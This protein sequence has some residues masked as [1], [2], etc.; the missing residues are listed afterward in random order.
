MSD[1]YAKADTS[2]YDQIGPTGNQKTGFEKFSDI[3]NTLT[4]IGN[5]KLLQTSIQRERLTLAKEQLN[6]LRSMMSARLSQK[7]GI[8]LDELYDDMRRAVALGIATP[9][10]TSQLLAEAA[11]SGD[12]PEKLRGFVN[13]QFMML[14]DASTRLDAI[15]SPIVSNTGG[16]TQINQ[17]NKLTGEVN[18]AASIPN[19]LS[20]AEQ[21]ERVPMTSADGMQRPGFKTVGDIAPDRLVPGGVEGE[22][23][24]PAPDP[25]PRPPPRP[26]ER[27]ADGFVQ[28]GPALGTEADIAAQV[29]MGNKLQ[30]FAGGVNDRRATL[31]NLSVLSGEFNAGAVAGP[32]ASLFSSINTVLPERYRVLVDEVAAQED[33]D[34]QATQLATAYEGMFGGGGGGTDARLTAA[35]KSSPSSYLSTEGGRKVYKVLQGYEDGLELKNAE[36]QKHKPVYGPGSYGRFEVQFNRTFDPRPFQMKYMTGEER[37]KYMSALPK[38]DRDY[39][40]GKLQDME[41][42]GWISPSDWGK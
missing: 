40:L 11:Q 36:W 14:M 19:T 29:E 30:Q 21:M 28:T 37:N 25:R 26:G 4:T 24:Q 22:L 1:T 42:V 6:E 2:I 5:N 34:K 7:G 18:N 12:D 33:Y 41:D 9:V 39:L 27:E 8:T 32:V 17:L 31:A 35:F 23:Q 10:Q 16:E 20:P 15:G 3:Q 13:N 38:Q